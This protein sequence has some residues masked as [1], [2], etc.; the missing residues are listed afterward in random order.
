MKARKLSMVFSVM[1]AASL[2]ASCKKDNGSDAPQQ[3]FAARTEQSGDNRTH[4]SGID[5]LW[6][7]HDQ[8]KVANHLEGNSAIKNAYTFELTEGETT[9]NG[10]FYTGADY[11]AD[12]FDESI[13]DYTAIYPATSGNTITGANA[14]QFSMPQ[15]QSPQSSWQNSFGDG[16]MAMMAVSGNKT[17]PF[18][19]LLGGLCL[20]LSGL[21]EHVTD[22]WITSNDAT[23]YLWG[24]FTADWNNG[25]PTLT[26]RLGG[27]GNNTVKLTGC[28]ATT[29]SST[30][31]QTFYIL[32]PPHTLKTG[33]TLSAYNG[34]TKVYE[35]TTTWSTNNDVIQRSRCRR[36][37]PSSGGGTG[38]DISE[39]ALPGLFSVSA[40]KQVYFSK[41]NLQYQASTGTW[42]FAEHQWDYVGDASNGTVYEGGA[43]CNNS[44][45]ASNYTGWIDLFGWGT[46]GWDNSGIP[47]YVYCYP[48]CSNWS[49]SYEGEIVATKYGPGSNS[50]VGDYADG[51]WGMHNPISNGGGAAGRW[52][53]LKGCVDN[54]SPNSFSPVPGDQ[55]GYQFPS[56]DFD[57]EWYYLL[58]VRSQTY[59]YA[60]ARLSLSSVTIN[61]LL[62]FPDG[63]TIPDGFTKTLKYNRGIG[64][65]GDAGVTSGYD[66]NVLTEVEW[67]MLE[68]ANVVFLPAAGDRP[69]T[70]VNDANSFIR[71]WT[72]TT[73]GDSNGLCLRVNADGT[74][75]ANNGSTRNIGYSVRLVCDYVP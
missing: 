48:Y 52:R 32:L 68:A 58:H 37:T 29:S 22:L 26:H 61:G 59:R 45:I 2:L 20:Q 73:T 8:I 62:L 47:T 41:G 38:I 11:A 33:F 51:D 50:L 71:Y 46:S 13:H 55:T 30:L 23:E 74:V 70:T 40:N 54:P 49:A 4:L 67:N 42:R 63:F 16:A 24:E 19:N 75:Q 10:V 43:K 34:A 72:S 66:D 7:A 3:G 17:L 15:E 27:A 39:G 31:T 21:H 36:L 35:H 56:P 9:G 5:V 25:D 64:G 6:N 44:L 1:V 53:S 14:A 65:T 60:Y 12:F 18:K 28:N 57:C 69:G